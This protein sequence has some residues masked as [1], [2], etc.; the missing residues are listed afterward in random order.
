MLVLSRKKN[1]SLRFPNLGISI[2]IL[3]VDG[4]T[5][6]VG[7]DA[8]RDI[9]VLRGELPES[10]MAETGSLGQSPQAEKEAEAQATSQA[11]HELRNRLNTASL[12]LHLLQRQ[13]DLGRVSDAE[14]TLA[15]AVDSL[16]DLDRLAAEPV[17]TRREI[18]ADGT[19]R[20]LIVEDNEN[21]R[22]LMVGFLE[23]CGYQV[24]AVEDGVA[25]MEYL[26]SHARPDIVLL[27]M[28][29]PRMDGPKTVSA[30]RS[31]PEYEGIKLFAVS[32]AEQAT[33]Q[34]PMGH[35]GVDHWFSKPLKPAE[36]AHDLAEEVTR[37]CSTAG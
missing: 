27:D 5:V 16:A 15:R 28:N 19:C 37:T 10:E 6:R 35:T 30:I 18:K 12:A 17:S 21:E 25:A 20:A 23:L 13:L 4:K 24:D 32:G 22:Q 9:R 36:F 7:V 3:R 31:N 14:K 11:R 2:E 29:M 8:P 26:E 34:L 33:L 1:Q